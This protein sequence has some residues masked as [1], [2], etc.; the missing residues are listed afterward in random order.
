VVA[1]DG[2]VVGVV[3]GLLVGVVVVGMVVG[4]GVVV[5]VVGVSKHASIASPTAD[6][7]SVVVFPPLR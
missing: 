5:G 7:P 2:V 4:V 1:G 6:T 3:V